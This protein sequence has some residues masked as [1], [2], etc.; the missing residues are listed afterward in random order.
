MRTDKSNKC[1]TESKWNNP[2]SFWEQAALITTKTLA[3]HDDPW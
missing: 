3:V 1:Y 2:G